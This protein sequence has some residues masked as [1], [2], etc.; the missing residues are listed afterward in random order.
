MVLYPA[1]IIT[2]RLLTIAWNS[3]CVVM[4]IVLATR[5]GAQDLEDTEA[6][7]NLPNQMLAGMDMSHGMY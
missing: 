2:C 4:I 5:T 1:T 6:S 7:G 3:W